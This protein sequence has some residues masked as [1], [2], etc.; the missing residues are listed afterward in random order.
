MTPGHTAL[1]R[2]ARARVW[3]VPAVLLLAVALPHLDQGDFRGDA[4]WYSAIGVQAWRTGSLWT[5]YADPGQAYFNKPPL[6]FWIHGLVLHLFGVSLV[7]ARLPAVIAALGCVLLTVA[8]TRELATRRAAVLAGVA[9]ALSLE[10]FRRVREVSLDMWQLL[11][12]LAALWLAAAAVKRGRGWLLVAAGVPLGLALLC[13]PLNGLL[14]IP[15]LAAWMLWA[16][17]ARMLPWLLGTLGA[18]VAVAA[19]WHISMWATHGQDFLDQYFG[20][21]IGERLAANPAGPISGNPPWF[22]LEKLGTLYWPWMIAVAIAAV[23]WLRGRP[24]S[25]GNLAGK[26]AVVWTV[27]WLAALTLYADRRDRYG[28][29]LYA[30]LGMLAGLGLAA[31][32]AMRFP[33]R[34][35]LRWLAPAFAAGAVAVAALPVRVHERN[36]THW[37]E[38]YAWLRQTEHIEGGFP[39]LWQG[40]FGGHHGARLYLEFGRW[41]H[42]TRN[43]WNRFIADP[44]SGVLLIYHRRDGLAPGP[45]ERILWRSSD[46]ELT[47]TRLDGPWTPEGAPDPGE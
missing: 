25:R 30:G 44:P 46:D 10:F 33:R 8:I 29:P 42:P 13:K 47:V 39:D 4:G 41:P 37:P 26:L 23:H 21:E 38:L 16:G 1:S 6:A 28:L 11:F 18:A 9:M 20:A 7:A 36:E 12:V 17:R 32:P 14:L 31:A 2:F 3:L 34:W 22:Y 5:I 45:T 24:L 19:P 43:R 35:M 40:A 27:A 15:I